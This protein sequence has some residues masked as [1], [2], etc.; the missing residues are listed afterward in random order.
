MHGALSKW[1][2]AV[3]P[4]RLITA[5]SMPSLHNCMLSKYIPISSINYRHQI[6]C[7]SWFSITHVST[8]HHWYGWPTAIK[9]FNRCG[10]WQNLHKEH[11]MKCSKKWEHVLRNTIL[12][13][14]V[15]S[16][17]WWI[18]HVRGCLH[19]RTPYSGKRISVLEQGY[20]SPGR[21]AA[22]FCWGKL[23][24][25]FVIPALHI[26]VILEQLADCSETTG[27]WCAY[28]L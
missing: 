3:T 20:F 16:P 23:H 17:V 6:L 22:S 27:G 19:R 25:Q 11:M 5:E 8:D 9:D 26:C 14:S 24:G 15:L 21:T 1:T 10:L 28:S 12:L 13:V 4:R 2:P 18:H 7:M